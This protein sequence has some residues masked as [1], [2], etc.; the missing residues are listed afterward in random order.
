MKINT[1]PGGHWS[2]ICLSI[3]AV[4]LLIVK[5]QAQNSDCDCAETFNQLIE[6]VEAN[7]IGLK[8]FQDNGKG[9]EYESRKRSYAA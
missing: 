4:C 8:H 7:Y 6:K 2:R 3:I 9:P 1:K 5:V